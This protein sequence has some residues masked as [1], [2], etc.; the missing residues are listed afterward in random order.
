M[1]LI[2]HHTRALMLPTGLVLQPNVRVVDPQWSFNKNS[3]GVKVWIANGL[4]ECL[5]EEPKSPEKPEMGDPV[6]N[7]LSE[8]D[9]IRAELKK[10]GVTA[11]HKTGLEKLKEMLKKAQAEQ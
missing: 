5:T 6:D 2:N 9:V 1:E 11:H 7:S 10:L 3:H 4:I 8:E